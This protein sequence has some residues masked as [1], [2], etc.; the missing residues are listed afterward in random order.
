MVVV[1]PGP[2]LTSNVDVAVLIRIL[3]GDREMG[4]VASLLHAASAKAISGTSCGVRCG[5]LNMDTSLLG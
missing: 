1:P 3:P 4:A 5:S 2:V